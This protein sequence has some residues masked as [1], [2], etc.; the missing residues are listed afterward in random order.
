MDDMR[1]LMGEHYSQPVVGIADETLGCGRYCGDFD[2]VERDHRR[3]AV[4]LIGLID[5][6]D[7]HAAARSSDVRVQAACNL[8]GDAC[9]PLRESLLAL[10]VMNVES[11]CRQ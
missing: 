6:D 4:R 11:C 2:E 8:F 5:E 3:P 7:I 1:V 9:E 10:M